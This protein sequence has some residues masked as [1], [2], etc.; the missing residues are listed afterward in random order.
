MMRG[1]IWT[2]EG[3][4]GLLRGLPPALTLAGRPQS[5]VCPRQG[6]HFPR[7]QTEAGDSGDPQGHIASEQQACVTRQHPLGCWLR[8]DTVPRGA[9]GRPHCKC[10]AGASASFEGPSRGV[11]ATGQR[12][13]VTSDLVSS[14]TRTTLGRLPCANLGQLDRPLGTTR[15]GEQRTGDV[16]GIGGVAGPTKAVQAQPRGRGS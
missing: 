13:K 7:R 2:P 1:R 11:T 10:K 5:P 3:L 12:D 9:L 14:W 8:V 6:R 4:C 16:P 15:R